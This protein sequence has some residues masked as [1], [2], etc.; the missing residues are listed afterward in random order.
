MVVYKAME[1]TLTILLRRAQK[2]DRGAEQAAFARMNQ[3]LLA[4]AHSLLRRER[5]DHTLETQSLLSE[6]FLTRL[7][8]LQAP[9]QNREHYYALVGQAM[10]QVLIDHSRHK[11]AAKRT[12]PAGL[13]AHLAE[14]ELDPATKLAVWGVLD[15]LRALDHHAAE[16]IT[17]RFVEGLSIE[18]TARQ[19]GRADWRVRA[20][21]EFGLSWM[22]SQLRG[23]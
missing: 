10:R 19:Q 11:R 20:D 9:I 8:R 6:A 3:R 2:G 5:A 14:R 1:G 18:A 16:A 21:C 22:S 17:L 4:L 15:R 12:D 7:R 23:E 13:R